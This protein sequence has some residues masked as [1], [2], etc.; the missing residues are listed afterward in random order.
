MHQ[1]EVLSSDAFPLAVFSYGDS[2]TAR[3]GVLI[4]PAMGVEQAFYSA[5][6][7]WLAEQGYYVLSFDYRGMG[8]SRPPQYAH[9]LRGFEADILTWA[10]RDAASVLDHLAERMA[11]RPVLWIGHSLGGQILGLLPNRSLVDAAVTVAAGSGYW[12]D[13]AARLKRVVWFLW[14]VLVPLLLPVFGY[15]PG[16]KLRMV[17][18]LPAGVMA[19][20]RSWCLARDYLFGLE[21]EAVR[22]QYAEL[23]SPML[24][25][26]FTDDE[27]LSPRNIE[28]LHRF[29]R[30]AAPQLRLI[31]PR[32]AQVK[33]IG[34]FG[35][36]R[37]RFADTLWPLAGLWLSRFAQ[38]G[39]P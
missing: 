15:F 6:A 38:K 17:G 5:F 16:R 3:A 20:W 34:H 32:E 28:S 23:K 11:G 18:D 4:A 33:Q 37:K 25:L 29:Y 12:R 14:F 36:F 21:G 1:H 39:N 24:A 22:R 31:H 7:R 10:R 35:F 27:M 2:Q 19:Q 26:Y 8:H 13:N 9:S 30:D